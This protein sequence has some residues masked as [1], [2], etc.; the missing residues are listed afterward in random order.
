MGSSQAFIDLERG[1]TTTT[2]QAGGP[3]RPGVD[4]VAGRM[5]TRLAAQAAAEGLLEVGY[6]VVGT[7]VGDLVVA[8]SPRGLVRVAFVEISTR[9]DI[10]AQLAADIGPRLLEAPGRLDDVATQLDDYFAGRRRD[11]D[12]A[13]DLQLAHGFRREVI[14]ALP[15]IP[16]GSTASYSDLARRVDNPRA[17]RAVGSACATN[18][19]PIVLPC[20]RV[21]RADGSLGRYA[22]GAAA[23]RTLL[24]LEGALL[25]P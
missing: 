11:F 18:P 12:L 5:R 4:D 20:H 24:T 13:L 10:V 14:T 1:G 23:K 17:V 21:V 8:A 19:L 3:G 9:D 2:V 22:G 15:T 25:P 7:P 16:S 6:R